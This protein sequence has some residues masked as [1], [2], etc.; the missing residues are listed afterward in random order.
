MDD[1]LL[2]RRYEYDGKPVRDLN[3]N[4]AESLQRTKEK[5]ETGEYDT[6][7]YE[8]SI[9]GGNSF[10]TL[11][12]K[13]R[14]GLPVNVVICSDCGLI[15][16]NP[17]FTPAASSKFYDEEYRVLYDLKD[18]DHSFNK[19][20]NEAP[21]IY[22]YV[23]SNINLSRS[24]ANILEIG[25]GYGGLVSY[26]DQ[27]GHTIVGCDLDSEAIQYG[28]E[29]GLPVKNSDIRDLNLNWQPN[30]IILDDVL[31]HLSR[32]TELLN[33]VRDEYDEAYIFIDL[34]GVKNLHYRRRF[35]QGDFLRYIHIAHTHHFSLRTLENLMG[36]SG[37]EKI[38]GDER[39]RSLFKTYNRQNNSKYDIK[40]DYE[41]TITHIRELERYR[42]LRINKVAT[43]HRNPMTI[44]LLKKTGLFSS[45]KKL[46]NIFD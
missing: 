35:Y 15:Q 40:A 19:Q 5:I 25:C 13:D 6:T 17:R 26:F 29:K 22:E 41:S 4:Q 12:E 37:F 23:M 33:Y 20:L 36:I 43:L 14:W 44:Q 34:P 45:A 42:R 27:K 18:A 30:V 21:E 3:D 8:C 32:P 7:S 11:S 24:D 16:N 39:I 2:G 9:C 1:P 31:E 10:R 46:Y 28:K 38:S